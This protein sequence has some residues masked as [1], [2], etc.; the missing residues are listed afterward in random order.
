MWYAPFCAYSSHVMLPSIL[1]PWRKRQ[2]LFL[3][4]GRWVPQSR[5]LCRRTVLDTAAGTDRVV[6][7]FSTDTPDDAVGSAAHARELGMRYVT[8]AVMVPTPL[9]GTEDCFVIYVGGE[10]DL[11]EITPLF[12]A[13]NSAPRLSVKSK[14]QSVQ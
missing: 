3:G 11:C 12:D 7:N 8:G 4:W 5:A 14:T 6:V 2:S 13:S 10:T 1:E 9:V